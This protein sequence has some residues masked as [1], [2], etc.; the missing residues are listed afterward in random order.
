[1]QV[2]V[3]HAYGE[4]AVPNSGGHPF[5]RSTA[6][7]ATGEDSPPA[8]FEQLP[9]AWDLAAGEDETPIVKVDPIAQPADMRKTADEDEQG[10]RRCY[11]ALARL[12]VLDNDFLQRAFPTDLA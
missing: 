5:H 9:L 11:A 1:M 7:V 4:R 2:L 10:L 6:D 8:G 12:Q 3:N